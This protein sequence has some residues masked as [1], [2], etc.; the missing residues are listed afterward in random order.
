M[1]NEISHGRGGAGNFNVDDTKYVDGE[2]VRAG[3]EGSHGDGAYS[4]GRGGAGNISDV[5]T[6]AIERRDQDFI[7]ESAVRPSQD[8]RDYHTGRGGA[9][10]EFKEGSEKVSLDISGEKPA[11]KPIVHRALHAPQSVADR[12]KQKL[13]GLG[14]K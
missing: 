13:F 11:E 5:G 14:K 7:P 3:P 10:N 4:S 1:T 2:V 12:L 6:K 8:G 9:G